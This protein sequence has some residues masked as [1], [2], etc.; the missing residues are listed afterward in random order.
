MNRFNKTGRKKGQTVHLIS[1]AWFDTWRIYTSF[2]V[3][4]KMLYLSF[5]F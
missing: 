2:E 1:S 4:D 3:H 5:R